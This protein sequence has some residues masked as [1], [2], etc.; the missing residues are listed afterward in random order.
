[1]N[2]LVRPSSYFTGGIAASAPSGVLATIPNPPPEVTRLPAGTTL[3]GVVVGDDGKGHVLA[4]DLPMPVC[5]K[6]ANALAALG[7]SD[8]TVTGSTWHYT[9]GGCC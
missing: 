8:L 7:H 1:M 9:G 4:R 2:D 6:T 5:D 3:R